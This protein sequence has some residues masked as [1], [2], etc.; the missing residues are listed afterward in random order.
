MRGTVEINPGEEMD[1][2][3]EEGREWYK[4]HAMCLR[5]KTRKGLYD[6]L[7]MAEL[8]KPHILMLCFD[9][10][11][12]DETPSSN[13]IRNLIKLEQYFHNITSFR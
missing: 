6:K 8:M 2:D 13:L 10:K 12:S 7:M 4:S 5:E 1:T 3:P 9:D 11:S